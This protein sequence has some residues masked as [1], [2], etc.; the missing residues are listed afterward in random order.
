M[1]KIKVIK[2]YLTSIIILN[3]FYGLQFLF[4]GVV[5]LIISSFRNIY[6]LSAIF[7]I[8]LSLIAL[9]NCLF[10]LKSNIMGI[11]LTVLNFLIYSVLLLLGFIFYSYLE[12][13]S[14]DW[15]SSI[16]WKTL[17]GFFI[18][19]IFFSNFSSLFVIIIFE[20]Y[21][22]PIIYNFAVLNFFHALL[23][24]VIACLLFKK[25]NEIE[26]FFNEKCNS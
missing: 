17:N 7:F 1:L 12:F 4:T 10:I 2:T 9:L 15:E 19:V 16:L 20:K 11:R 23:L 21:Y 24:I 18:M 14:F 26:D 8:I 5:F 13:S 6:L 3:L 22:N 25:Y